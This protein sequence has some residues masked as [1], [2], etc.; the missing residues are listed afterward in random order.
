MHPALGEIYTEVRDSSGGIQLLVIRAL[1]LT[2]RN[3][4]KVYLDLH[5]S[6]TIPF[7]QKG[8]GRLSVASGVVIERMQLPTPLGGAEDPD[9]SRWRLPSDDHRRIGGRGGRR[10]AA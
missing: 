4:N 6:P 8:Q 2:V 1:D 7:F 5:V 9:R 10:S 3:I